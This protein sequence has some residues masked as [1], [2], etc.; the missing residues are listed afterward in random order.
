MK[1][2]S[3]NNKLKFPSFDIT[4]N[5][6]MDN[7]EYGKKSRLCYALNNPRIML[8]N[9]KKME[10]NEKLLNSK[11]FV[12]VLK[13]EILSSNYRK[14]RFFSSGDLYHIEQLE[15]IEKLCVELPFIKFW[16]STHSDFILF[17]YYENKTP[18]NN[19]NVVLS[20]QIP[21]TEAPTFLKSWCNKRL[22]SISNTTNN[23]KLSNCHASINHESCGLCER[24]FNHENITYFLHGKFAKKRLEKYEGK[25]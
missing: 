14:I 5:S 25:K 9:K 12:N 3:L 21:N 24:C 10:N 17:K 1:H 16:L 2:L 13:K 4:L 19:L 11:N 6:C 22:I 20:N 7:C 15:K 18:V 23:R 8:Y